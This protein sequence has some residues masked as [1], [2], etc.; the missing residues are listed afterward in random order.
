MVPRRLLIFDVLR[1]AGEEEEEEE[2]EEDCKPVWLSIGNGWGITLRIEFQIDA[3]TFF[4]LA[5]LAAG[6]RL[7][8]DLIET[9]SAVGLIALQRICLQH[10]L[11]LTKHRH[12]NFVV[13]KLIQESPTWFCF[14]ICRAF[15]GKI[16]KIARHRC[17][18][19]VLERIIEHHGSG[20]DFFF[21]ELVSDAPRIVGN[22]Y[23][24]YVIQN[25]LENSPQV[26]RRRC[27]VSILTTAESNGQAGCYLRCT[28]STAFERSTD[29]YILRLLVPLRPLFQRVECNIENKAAA[30]ESQ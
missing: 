18:S 28:L 6:S 3:D 16:C 20:V 19:R 9:A 2:E 23:G 5:L 24:N 11:F 22:R 14:G 4:D 7:L 29:E 26:W 1:Q 27:L 15:A 17:G 8:Q 10:A 13:T 30:C 21:A 12:A 25:V